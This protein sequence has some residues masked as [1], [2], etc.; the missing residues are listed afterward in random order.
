MRVF[1]F[2]SALLAIPAAAQDGSQDVSKRTPENAH[3]FLNQ[4]M[5]G[6]KMGSAV[7][8]PEAAGLPSNAPLFWL[9]VVTWSKTTPCKSTYDTSAHPGGQVQTPIGTGTFGAIA[10]GRYSI[11]WTTITDVRRSEAD[12]ILASKVSPLFVRTPSEVMASRIGNA[13]QL[14]VETCDPA[15]ETG[16]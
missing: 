16:F 8:N 12:L 9:D 11:D 14:I 6:A 4:M 3:E 13:M 2:A 7:S 1:I 15:K 5:V 10:A